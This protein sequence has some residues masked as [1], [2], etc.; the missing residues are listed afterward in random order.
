ADLLG[1]PHPRSYG[2]FPRVIAKYVREDGA[3]TL[4][5]AIRKMSGWPAT[6]MRLAERGFLRAGFWADIV[7]FDYETI[8]DRATYQS[9]VEFPAG[10]D[11]V[12][13]NGTIVADHGKHTGARPGKVLYGPG[14]TAR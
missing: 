7:I 12:I 9:P 4:S 10:I 1:L 5:E 11:Y 8:Q 3:I 14:K 6:R 13:V 2:T